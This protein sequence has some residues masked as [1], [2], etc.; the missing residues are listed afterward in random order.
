MTKDDDRRLPHPWCA[1]LLEDVDRILWRWHR[2]LR[3]LYEARLPRDIAASKLWTLRMWHQLLNDGDMLGADLTERHV[4]RSYYHAKCCVIDEVGKHEQYQNL[5]FLDFVEALVRAAEQ[6]A[7][8][9]RAELNEADPP[10]AS[11]VEFR[12]ALDA[13]AITWDNWLVMRPP[14][15]AAPDASPLWFRVEQMFLLLFSRLEAKGLVKPA[16]GGK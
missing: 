11:I 10:A 9:S 4:N 12:H 1:L 5:P 3:A 15:R 6:K 14:A 13:A 2:R 7:I 8:P 16:K